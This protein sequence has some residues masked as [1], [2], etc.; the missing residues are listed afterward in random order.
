M[1]V[2]GKRAEGPR[3]VEPVSLSGLSP[4]DVLLGLTETGEGQP[5]PSLDAVSA[6]A[7]VGPALQPRMPD[8]RSDGANR[9]VDSVHSRCHP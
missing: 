5:S 8:G 1:D 2:A 3:L 7:E 4:G 6:A 9:T